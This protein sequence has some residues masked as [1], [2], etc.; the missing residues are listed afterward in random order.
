MKKNEEYIVTCI[1]DTDLNSGVVKIDDMVVFVPNLLIGEKAKIKIV[2][3]NKKYAFGIIIELLKPSINRQELTC[4][5]AKTCGGCQLQHMSYAYQLDYKYKHVKKLFEGIEVKPILGMDNPWYYRNK[6]QFPVKIK[7]GKVQMGFYRQHSNDVVTCKECKIQD[8]VI[9]EVFSFIQK[10]ITLKMAQDLRHVFIRHSSTDEIQ[11][12]FIGKNEK[13]IV[14]LSDQ[15]KNTFANITSIVFNYNTRN[16]NVILGDTYK[17]LYGNDSIIEECLGNKVKL[18]F[19]AFFQVNPKQMEVLYSQ[20]IKAAN[21]SGNET[22]IDMYAGTGTIGM[23]VSQYAKSVI[24]VEIVKEAVDNANDN[25]KMNHLDHCHY[26]CQDATDFA[27]DHKEDKIDV[28]FIDPPRKGMTENGIKDTIT[29][30]PDKIVYVSCNPKTLS[31]DLKIFKEYG[32]QCEYVQ[33][34]DMFCQTIGLECV[35]K[36]TKIV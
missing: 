14:S 6:A 13:N 10:K 36:L 2:K 1:D 15:L 29:M 30:Q 27:H 23:A 22:C 18:H 12:V 5:V 26:V 31:R 8:H 7:D 24:G 35:A 34:V 9:N 28:I 21:L 17:V 16:D 25:T 4:E 32:Y 11:V 20:A 19:K 33:P 3:V